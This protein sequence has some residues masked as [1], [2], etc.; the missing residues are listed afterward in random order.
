M[1]LMLL[2]FPRSASAG[3]GPFGQIVI[4]GGGLPADI[5]VTDRHLLDFFA[6]S[7]FYETRIPA[8][9]APGIGYTV[10]RGSFTDSGAFAPWDRLRYYPG[11][12]WHPS[13]VYYEG[14][15]NGQSEYD[16][17]WYRASANADKYMLPLLSGQPVAPMSA[18]SPVP[19]IAAVVLSALLVVG[20][21]AQTRR[22]MAVS[23]PAH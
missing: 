18:P 15:L 6:F 5:E 12:D 17:H 10:T 4:S 2:S 22:G 13:Y 19:L 11:S 21:A 14:L 3:G 9:A 7:N 20:L 16:G 23:S 8:P 1:L